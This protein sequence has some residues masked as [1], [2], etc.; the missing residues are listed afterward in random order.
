MA[1]LKEPPDAATGQQIDA[2]LQRLRNSKEVGADL[3]QVLDIAIG[4]TGADM[5]T[6]QR[7]D[8]RADCLTIVASR[9]FSSEALTF[10]G[11]VR[12]DTNT[13]CAAALT[14]RMHV[15]VEDVS[16]SYLFVGTRELDMLRADGIAAVYST[17]LISSNGRLWGV[18][19]TYFREPQR[20]SEFDHA[21][22]DR[23]A[24]QV[25][26]SLEQREGLV[27]SQHFHSKQVPQRSQSGD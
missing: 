5:G 20:E 11:V 1:N 10:F 8:E 27:P 7:L 13:T 26:D 19:S 3:L 15:F 21:P 2:V 18:F 12:R 22:L 24:V 16:T 14:R 17:P 6:L 25:A 23:F 4:A 9:G